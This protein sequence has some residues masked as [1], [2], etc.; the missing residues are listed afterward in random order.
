MGLEDGSTLHQVPVQVRFGPRTKR[1]GTELDLTVLKVQGLLYRAGD[2][3]VWHIRTSCNLCSLRRASRV[4]TPGRT[5]LNGLLSLYGF[6]LSPT[7][8]ALV[9]ILPRRDGRIDPMS[10]TTCSD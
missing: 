9:H 2:V 10:H 8:L 4:C 5:S 1:G 7:H 6:R 3:T